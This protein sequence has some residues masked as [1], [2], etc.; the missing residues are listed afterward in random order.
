[1]HRFSIA[2]H[3]SLR[4]REVRRS[5]LDGVPGVGTSR[6]EALLR[7]FGSVRSLMERS[8]DEIAEVPG[9]GITTARRIKEA[10]QEAGSGD[11]PAA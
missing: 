4:E 9:I 6:K 11:G 8:P 10:L 2:Y 3:R 5:L 7:K 1:V